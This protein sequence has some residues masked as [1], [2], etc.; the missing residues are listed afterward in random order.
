ME[1]PRL[2]MMDLE[3]S[4]L[5]HFKAQLHTPVTLDTLCQDQLQCL[6]WLVGIGALDQHVQ[7][8]N[9]IISVDKCLINIVVR[10]PEYYKDL[11]LVYGL[12]SKHVI[13]YR[14]FSF[15]IFK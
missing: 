13:K 10:L 9:S 4:L 1:H 11:L 3:H 6:V 5:L 8:C 2:L 15:K 14:C 7:V 12:P